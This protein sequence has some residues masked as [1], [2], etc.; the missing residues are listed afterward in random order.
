[1]HDAGGYSSLQR[2]KKPN[3]FISL[4]C[5]RGVN[6]VLTCQIGTPPNGALH[7]LSK[8]TSVLAKIM[9]YIVAPIINIV[10]PIILIV[11][12]PQ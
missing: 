10:A 9:C 12:P 1:M 5:I 7:R 6:R 3:A 2:E 11:L 4:M 8:L